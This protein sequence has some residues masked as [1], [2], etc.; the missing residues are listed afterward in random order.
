MFG[1]GGY[2]ITDKLSMPPSFP[3]VTEVDRKKSNVDLAAMLS[4][5]PA[6][7]T[8]TVLVSHAANILM[9]TGDDL[10]TQGEAVIFRPDGTG[11]YTRVFSVVPDEWTRASS[12]IPSR[13]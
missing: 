4:E 6:A 13:R 2:I 1:K 11:G 10:R 8:N 7:G 3:G 5:K 12:V 9:L